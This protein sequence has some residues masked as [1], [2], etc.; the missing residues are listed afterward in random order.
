MALVGEAQGKVSTA[1][2]VMV[3]ELCTKR[4]GSGD[5]VKMVKLKLGSGLLGNRV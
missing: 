5:A 4:A 2:V 3:R 1:D